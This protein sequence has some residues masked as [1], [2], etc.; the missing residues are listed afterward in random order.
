MAALA[1][2][3]DL[4]RRAASSPV[5]HALLHEV[6]VGAVGTTVAPAARASTLHARFAE[7]PFG[8]Q[9]PSCRR[10][11]T[12]C[13]QAKRALRAARLAGA[14]PAGATLA[15][16]E[17]FVAAVLVRHGLLQW[18]Q[19]IRRA[20][21]RRSR[22]RAWA[23]VARVPALEGVPAACRGSRSE[24]GSASGSRRESQGER[25]I[26]LRAA[27][28]VQGAVHPRKS[29]RASAPS[30]TASGALSSGACAVQA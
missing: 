17:A 13:L 18:G 11:G 12:C 21:C 5:A 10:Q 27:A 29:D 23:R 30:R 2:Y 3:R 24:P 6:L 19:S 9:R 20:G 8:R 1:R 7:P 22:P 25:R 26:A 4:R 16:F 14:L 15:G 28:K